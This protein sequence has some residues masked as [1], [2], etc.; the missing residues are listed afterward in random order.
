MPI[1]VMDG[2]IST[3]TL[4]HTFRLDESMQKRQPIIPPKFNGQGND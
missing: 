2:K 3:H 4:V 1:R